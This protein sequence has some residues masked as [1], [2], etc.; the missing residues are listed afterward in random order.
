MPDVLEVPG[1]AHREMEQMLYL[2]RGAAE[3][4]AGLRERGGALVSAVARHEAAEV[5]YSWPAVKVEAA[6][7]DPLAAEG[8]EQE[9]G[10]REMLTEP[11]GTAPGDPLFI[12]LMTRFSRAA[13]AHIACVE[14]QVWPGLRTALAADEACWLGGEL[15][16]A[17]KISPGRVIPAHPAQP[18]PAEGR[19]PAVA[20]PLTGSVSWLGP[21]QLGHRLCA[22]PRRAAGPACRGHSFRGRRWSAPRVWP[23]IGA[24]HD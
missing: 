11:D 18:G 4:T 2:L 14:Q 16:A 7:G 24:G 6:E 3:P 23:G 1:A 12:L 19:R 21:R 20:R 10:A 8:A 13:R 22:L 15:A 5:Q 17:A 9:T